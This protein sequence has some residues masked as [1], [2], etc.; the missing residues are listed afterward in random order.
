[1]I[2]F[3]FGVLFSHY[4]PLAY[5]VEPSFPTQSPTTSPTCM[6]PEP[7]VSQPSVSPSFSPTIL[8]QRRPQCILVAGPESSG[9]HLIFNIVSFALGFSESDDF[10]YH[11]GVVTEELGDINFKNGGHA[12]WHRSLPHGG[13]AHTNITE[14]DPKLNPFAY[15]CCKR[16]FVD[17]SRM[18]DY[19]GDRCDF[20]GSRYYCY[21]AF[22]GLCSAHFE[23]RNCNTSYI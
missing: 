14:P 1:M 23:S 12:I 15:K 5:S 10:T 7:S 22:P 13:G 11:H 3:N 16:I 6:T 17:P 4:S 21:K 2:S 20:Y 8:L 19:A 18:L 9:T